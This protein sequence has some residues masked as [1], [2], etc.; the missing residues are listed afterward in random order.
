MKTIRK[1]YQGS[2]PTN[3]VLNTQTDSTTDTYSCDYIN[4]LGIPVVHTGTTEPTS[5][6]GKNGDIY[7]MTE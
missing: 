1:E 3:K 6:I 4:N 7:I 5:D 2:I